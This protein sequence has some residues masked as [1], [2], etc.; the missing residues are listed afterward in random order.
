MKKSFIISVLLVALVAGF[1]SCKKD[2]K[3]KA[4]D[5]TL[6]KVGND[7]WNVS[8]TSISWIYPKGT[9]V[10]N[11]IPTIEVSAGARVNPESGKAQ[12]FSSAVTYTVTAEDGKTTKIYTA[13]ATVSTTT[14]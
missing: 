8:G 7:A 10:S 12:D 14:D 4:C 5:I 2:D 1:S 3:S 6:F 13:K 11:L 9:E